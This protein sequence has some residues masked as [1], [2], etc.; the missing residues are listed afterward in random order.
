MESSMEI[1]K[2]II[3]HTFPLYSP[4]VLSISCFSVSLSHFAYIDKLIPSLSLS[5]C[6]FLPSPFLSPKGNIATGR[7]CISLQCILL[8]PYNFIVF[9]NSNP[10]SLAT[11]YLAS[12][13]GNNLNVFSGK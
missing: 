9:H 12:R 1:S 13:A 10:Y 8:P 4:I 7:P 3:L 2:R 6:F 5:L 11:T